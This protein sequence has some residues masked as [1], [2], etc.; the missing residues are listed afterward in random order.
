MKKNAARANPVV[1]ES[2]PDEDHGTMVF[3]VG[4]EESGVEA[5]AEQLG[6][7]GLRSVPA[8]IATGEADD[9]GSALDRF[10]D[11][12]F[13]DLGA[14]ADMPVLLPRLDLLNRLKHRQEE[15]RS[16]LGAVLGAPADDADDAGDQPVD[17]GTPGHEGHSVW[18][19]GDPRNTV[20]APFWI[21]AAGLSARIVLVHRAP[22]EAAR[23]LTSTNGQSIDRNLNL[24][25]QFN[26][27][28]LSLWEVQTGLIVGIEAF[29]D[30]VAGGLDG[31]NEFVH[32]LGV[33]PTPVQLAQARDS[34]SGFGR[35]RSDQSDVV[36]ANQFLVLDRALSQADM[37][38]SVDSEAMAREFTGYYDQEYYEHY[39]DND[40]DPYRPGA[41]QWTTFFSMVADRITN[42]LHPTTALDAGCAIGF[43]V[44]ALRNQGVDARGIDVSEWAISQVPPDVRPFCSVA[45]LTDEIEGHFDLI[46]IVEVIEHMPDSVA[47]LV[48]ANLTRHAEAVLFSSTSDGFEEPTHINVHTADHWAALF[49]ANGFIRD[50]SYDATYLTQDAILFRRGSLDSQTLVIGYERALWYSGRSARQHLD[51]VRVDRDHQVEMLRVESDRSNGLTGALES[52]TAEIEEISS[53]LR[54]AEAACRAERLEANAQGFHADLAISSLNQELAQAIQVKDELERRVAHLESRPLA[55]LAAM[56]RRIFR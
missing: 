27:A 28:A 45:S 36:V 46:T 29:S 23:S 14:T 5:I 8:G 2:A 42:D 17:G 47:G 43:L 1:R 56:A 6:H 13:D 7:L 3:V 51:D 31:L 44:E 54:S 35:P 33:N 11:Q 52:S 48:I 49:A 26:R 32:G 16:L 15:A 37:V 34:F 20:L 18:V 4:V 24:W 21:E 9:A 12:L 19:W 40:S 55:R 22:G 50:F 10:I 39:G 30:D 41:P 25:D 38:A 53:A